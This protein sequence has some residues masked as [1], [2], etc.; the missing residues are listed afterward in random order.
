MDK[1]ILFVIFTNSLYDLLCI[2]PNGFCIHPTTPHLNF[3][4]MQYKMFMDKLILHLYQ[5]ILIL[6]LKY[7]IV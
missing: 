7:W 2:H 1:L 5:L 6:S 4:F 3:L